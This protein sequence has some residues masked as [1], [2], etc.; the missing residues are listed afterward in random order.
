[1]FLIGLGFLLSVFVAFLIIQIISGEKLKDVS[2]YK[3]KIAETEMQA[4]QAQMNPH[5]FLTA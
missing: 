3:Q 4:L 1:L 5:F 2:Q